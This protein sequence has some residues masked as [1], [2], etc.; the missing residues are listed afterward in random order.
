MDDI[1]AQVEAWD[2]Y[3]KLP[4]EI[5]GFRLEKQMRVDEPRLYL[6]SYDCPARR[7][8]LFAFYDKATKDFMAH[9]VIGL[10]DFC[11]I[12]FIT[13][14]LVSF[15]RMLAERMETVLK[16][17]AVFNAATLGGVFREKKILEQD[18]KSILPAEAAGF[19]LFILPDE[20]LKII[21]G[22]Y[23]IMDYCD[24]Q[25]ESNL[26]VY[27]NIYRDEFFSERRIRRLPEMVTRFDS[28]TLTD[29]IAKLNEGLLPELT[30]MRSQL[31]ETE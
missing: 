12:Q 29:L 20:P 27:Y 24:F 7:R 13:T 26:T 22:S 4:E 2:F 8:K 21:N 15:E 11:D 31:T 1:I 14:D 3:K 6:F 9:T 17:M 25:T 23:I 30:G 28:K 16:N 19:T 18:W 10:F 5:H